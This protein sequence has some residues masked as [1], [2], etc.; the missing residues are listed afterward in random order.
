VTIRFDHFLAFPN[1]ISIIQID[2]EFEGTE[3]NILK[4]SDDDVDEEYGVGYLPR[5]VYFESGIPKPFNGDESN[6]DMV[7]Q[8]ISKELATN[9]LV[10]VSKS[11]LEKLV[12]KFPH[13]GVIFVDDENKEEMTMVLDLEKSILDDIEE[14]ELTLV[15]IDDAE[16]AEE[17]G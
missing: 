6:K 14:N 17:L 4:C 2:D 8:W 16:Y 12:E 7:K 13:I 10:S 15:L 9:K 1:L 5:F 11:I 3:I